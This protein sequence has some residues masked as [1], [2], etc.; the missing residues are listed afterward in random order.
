MNVVFVSNYLTHHQLPFCRAMNAKLG[1]DF[2]FVETEQMAQERID[3]GWQLKEKNDI[4]I[5]KSY[6]DDKAYHD[7]C[8]KIVKADAVIIG[9]TKDEYIEKRLEENGLIFRYE[10]RI[11]KKSWIKILDPRIL[12]MIYAT[13]VKNQKKKVYMLCASAYLPQELELFHL[14]KNKMFKWG[15]FPETYY[16]NVDELMEKKKHDVTEI[17][18]CAR[19]I[20]WK[21][22]EKVI[23]V[24]EGLAYRKLKFHITMLGD[25]DLKETIKK[26]I[27]K[28]N[29]D[30]Y[31]SVKGAIPAAEVRYY[32]EMANIFLA[33]SDRNEG[34][35][36]VINEAMNSGCAVVANRMMGAVPYLIK[37]DENGYAYRSNKECVSYLNTLIEN[38]EKRK[39]LGVNAYKTI[40]DQWNA[41]KAAESLLRIMDG[42]IKNDMLN[43]PLIG[44]GS[45]AL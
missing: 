21:H 40:V 41:E 35:G 17:L 5:M 43:T 8:E 42:I 29:F 23:A 44:A 22:P 34:W 3:L 36:A 20:D 39:L 6:I 9:G 32:M 27:S 14:Y 26:K 28:K 25:G 13:H 18:W 11:F 31:I 7:C 19:F 24:A 12:H 10:E 2:C 38:E 33:T 15:Y 1:R 4:Y 30:K 37:D 16:Y 45:V